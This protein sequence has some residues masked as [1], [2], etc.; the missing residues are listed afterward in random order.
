MKRLKYTLMFL[1][2]LTIV[3]N[4]DED[5]MVNVTPQ[6]DL[7]ASVAWDNEEMARAS[8]NGVINAFRGPFN[9]DSFLHWFEHRTGH[10]QFGMA[11]GGAGTANWNHLFDNTMIAGSSPGTNWSGLYNVLNGTNQAIKYL[12][13]IKFTNETEKQRLLAQSYF[14][15]AYVFYALARIYGDVPLPTKPFESVKGDLFLERSPVSD[16]FEQI[17]AD[18]K[19]ALEH[20]PDN[21]PRDRVLPSE[22]AVNMLK[23][24]VYI[25]TAKRMGGGDADLAI[26]EDAVDNVLDN[27]NYRLL[28][29]YEEVFRNKQNDESI[30]EIYRSFDEGGNHYSR[31]MLLSVTNVPP[32]FHNDPVPVGTGNQRNIFT[33][34][35]VENYLRKDP[36]DSRYEV[37]YGFFELGG[38]EYVWINK[39]LGEMRDGNRHNIDNTLIYRYAEAILFKAEILNARGRPD[40]AITYLNQIAERAYGDDNYYSTGMSQADVDDAILDERLIEF[41]AEGKSWMDYIRMGKAFERIPSLIGREGEHEGNILLFP[42]D[43]TTIERNP[44][45]T[46]TPGF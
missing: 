12:P 16:V 28:D 38:N 19:Q 43:P 11:G 24:D 23:T 4:C 33:E 41:A 1:L 46:Q 20:M 9:G 13:G 44:K 42:V 10:L 2:L 14:I 25:W 39:F 6:S 3:N 26:A 15:R 30:F 8:T 34:H 40:E 29:D 45:I 7:T 22:A 37:N 18:I 36:N 5:A 21:N 17:K 27:P 35:F 31:E 32:P